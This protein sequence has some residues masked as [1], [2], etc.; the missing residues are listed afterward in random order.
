[1]PKSLQIHNF[2]RAF[3]RA[4]SYLK[5]PYAEM[6]NI[7]WEGILDSTYHFEENIRNLEEAY[8]QY[9]WKVPEKR[10]ELERIRPEWKKF[11]VRDDFDV[12]TTKVEI[13]PHKVKAK[14]RAYLHGRIQVTV[15]RKWIGRK[16]TVSVRIPAEK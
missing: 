13:K 4:N 14:H 16:A 6:D 3:L 2:K 11:A 8:P 15:D 9:R 5:D 7:D 10:K 1:M 12:Y